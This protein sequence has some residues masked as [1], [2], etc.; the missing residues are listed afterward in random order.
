VNAITTENLS[1]V[2]GE[3]TPGNQST[4]YG[5]NRD[6]FPDWTERLVVSWIPAGRGNSPA[7]DGCL[8]L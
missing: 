1:W 2:T 4:W 5:M 7:V 3:Q 8:A 6:A